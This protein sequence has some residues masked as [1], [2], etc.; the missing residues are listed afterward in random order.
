M[1]DRREKYSV[2]FENHCSRLLLYFNLC[3]SSL[4]SS[5]RKLSQDISSSLYVFYSF[6]FACKQQLSKFLNDN[7]DLAFVFSVMLS[8]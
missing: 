6:G 2:K 5:I 3:K 7:G 1:G 8:P 4:C